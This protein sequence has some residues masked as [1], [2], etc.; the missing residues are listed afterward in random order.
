[1]HAQLHSCVANWPSTQRNAPAATFGRTRRLAKLLGGDLHVTDRAD[2]DHGVQYQLRVPLLLAPVPSSP[3]PAVISPQGEPPRM[4]LR[5]KVLIVDDSEGNRRLA[6]RMLLQLGCEVLEASD[7]DEVLPAL[8]GASSSDSGHPV[9]VVLMDIEMPR[10]D[11]VTALRE[12]RRAG[13]AT[14]VIAVTGNADVEAVADCAWRARLRV[15]D[16]QVFSRTE[17]MLPADVARGFNRVL[18]KPFSRVQLRG[19]ILAEC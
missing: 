11:G 15:P 18:P 4:L 6:R 7:G 5:K 2:G 16:V 8:A 3:Q 1:V 13:L 10:M 19:A 12:M 9:D 14:P 17:L